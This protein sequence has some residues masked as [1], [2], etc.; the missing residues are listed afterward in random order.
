LNWWDARRRNCLVGLERKEREE[1]KLER[2]EE[3]KLELT[4]E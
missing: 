4:L 3:M 2:M 1:G